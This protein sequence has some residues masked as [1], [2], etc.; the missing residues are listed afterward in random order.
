MDIDDEV[1]KAA[2]RVLDLEQCW[3]RLGRHRLGRRPAMSLV[4][5]E[6]KDQLTVK[7]YSLPGRAIAWFLATA[8]IA[9]TTSWTV[10][11][12]LVM[13]GTSWGWEM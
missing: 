8:R 13:S 4:R 9:V 6:S 10:S 5:I 7:T 3:P 1:V 2:V 12:H 11:A